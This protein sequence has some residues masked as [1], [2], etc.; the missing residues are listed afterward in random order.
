MRYR[1]TRQRRGTTFL[2]AAFA[3]PVTFFFICAT[4]IGGMGIFRYQETAHLAREAARFASVHAGTYASEN[5]SAITA[6]TLP[7]VNETYLTDSV[8]KARAVGLDTSQ[9]KVAVTINTPNGSSDWDATGSNNSRAIYTTA[10]QNGSS[11]DVVN[12]VSVTVTYKWF[13]ELYLVGPITLASTS[14]MPMSY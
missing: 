1:K 5:V 6:G 7:N 11:V 10:T 8:V 13:P 12:T 3:L 4:I 9:L 2:Q 14:V